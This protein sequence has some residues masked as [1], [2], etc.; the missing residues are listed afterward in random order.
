MM[1]IGGAG[2]SEGKNTMEVFTLKFFTQCSSQLWSYIIDLILF[3][4]PPAVV[5][6][7]ASGWNLRDKPL[8]SAEGGGN[9]SFLIY[10]LCSFTPIIKIF[11][12]YSPDWIFFKERYNLKIDIVKFYNF[13]IQSFSPIINIS[14]IKVFN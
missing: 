13:K 5:P 4:P 11:S 10:Y 3:P 8:A 9:M 6:D 7:A 2:W 12:L 14:A 1:W